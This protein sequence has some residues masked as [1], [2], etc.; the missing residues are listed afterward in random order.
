MKTRLCIAAI[1]FVGLFISAAPSAQE[2]VT[3]TSAVYVDPGATE[4]RVASLYLNVLGSEIR[5]TLAEVDTGTSNFKSNGKELQCTYAGAEADALIKTLNKMNFSTTSMQKR[6]VQQC[7]ADGK[8]G[9]GTIS[10]IPQ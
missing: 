4:F 9:A 1:L 3:F 8:L 6:I 5:S 7:Q 2:K 10:G